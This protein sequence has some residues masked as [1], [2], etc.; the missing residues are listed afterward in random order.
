LQKG[1][2]N[3]HHSILNVERKFLERFDAFEAG[4]TSSGETMMVG[5]TF[6]SAGQPDIPVRCFDL[7]TGRR[8]AVAALWRAAKAEKS[9]EPADRNV[10]VTGTTALRSIRTMKIRASAG[11]RLRL[12][13]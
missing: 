1:T 7:A 13:L 8:R 11:T 9:P 10:C 4:P 3:I 12:K 6:L 2:S 5:Q